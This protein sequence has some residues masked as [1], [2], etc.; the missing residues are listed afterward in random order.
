MTEEKKKEIREKI[1]PFI[2]AEKMFVDP[3]IIANTV[4]VDPRYGCLQL[5]KGIEDVAEALDKKITKSICNRD[6]PT[7]KPYMLQTF[8]FD[9]IMVCQTNDVEIEVKP[10]V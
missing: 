3:Q 5:T 4:A 2:K 6:N 7:S 8:Y 9:N 1:M 10:N